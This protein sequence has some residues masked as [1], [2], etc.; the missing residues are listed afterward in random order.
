MGLVRSALCVSALLLVTPDGGSGA[1]A[2]LLGAVEK[3]QG[4]KC[5]Q[6]IDAWPVQRSRW[7]VVLFKACS[8]YQGDENYSSSPVTQAALVGPDLKVTG[9]TTVE[10]ELSWEGA[11]V[12]QRYARLGDGLRVETSREGPLPS[13]HVTFTLTP[14]SDGTW[15]VVGKTTRFW[16]SGRYRDASSGEELAISAEATAAD[17]GPRKRTKGSVT[18][19]TPKRRAAVALQVMSMRFIDAPTKGSEDWELV[20]RFPQSRAAH[21]LR[22]DDADLPYA[23]KLFRRI[24]TEPDS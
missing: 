2:E 7:S 24:A 17:D 19:K 18:Y 14:R 9:V 21:R 23:S 15:Q 3:Q 1:R 6:F 20:V 11:S 22:F 4:G 16:F 13:S 8:R 5:F 10:H 12:G